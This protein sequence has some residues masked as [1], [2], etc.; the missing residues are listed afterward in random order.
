[1]VGANGAGKTWLARRFASAYDI[2]LIH[3]DALALLTGWQHRPRDEVARQRDAVTSGP[4]WV[5]EG[6]PS[7]LTRDVL[8]RATLV[9]W[10]DPPPRLRA[11][12]IFRRSL[13][14]LGRNRPEHPAGNRD[15]PGPRQFRFFLKA[16]TGGERFDAAIEAALAG[17][18]GT[19][20]RL[21]TKAEVSAFIKAARQG[22]EGF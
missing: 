14:Y 11:W 3:N 9:V 2:P 7:I 16:L 15:W 10:C 19:I 20:V 18:D 4:S 5:L 12:R 17:Y 6:G 22:A 21:R 8:S 13:Y 1:M